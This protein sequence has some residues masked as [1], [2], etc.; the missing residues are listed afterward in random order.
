MT[1]EGFV[2]GD[3]YIIDDETGLKIRASESMKRWDGARVD[4]R[5]WNPRQPQDL[6]KGREDRQIA[7]IVRSRP[8]DQ[9]VG[10][11]TTTVTVAKAIGATTISVDSAVR[12][13]VGDR[14]TFTLDNGDTWQT[15]IVEILDTETFRIPAPGLPRAIEVGAH[16]VNY[17]ALAEPYTG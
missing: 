3:N 4:R 15:S 10:P 11:L 16:V 2:L 5:N 9:F 6:V 13:L 8:V 14:I 7:D 17:T 12:M 1:R